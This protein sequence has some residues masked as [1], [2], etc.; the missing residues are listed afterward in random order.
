MFPALFLSPALVALIVV[1]VFPVLYTFVT[2]LQYYYLP[3]AAARAF[4]GLDN[5]A[6]LLRDDRFWNALRLTLTFVAASLAIETVFGFVVALLLMRQKR[7]L[8]VIRGALLL[9]IFITPIAVAFLWR[10]MFS[11]SLGLLNYVM[12]FVGLGPYQWIYSP[13]EAMPALILVE[14]WQHTPE[15]ALIIFTGLL[16]LPAE[17]DEAAKL[18]GASRWQ[19]FWRIRLPLLKPIVMVGVLFRVIDLFKTFD[20]FFILTRGGPGTATETLALYTYTSGFGFLKM[21]YASALATVLFGIVLLVCI[22]VVRWG[23]VDLG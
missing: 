8:G 15:L 7:G 23:E 10:L 2:S 18:D 1:N 5:Y 3:R 9:P 19:L 21:G 12:S 6:D 13:S 22:A 16:N 11:P 14:I 17:L 4:V 20:I